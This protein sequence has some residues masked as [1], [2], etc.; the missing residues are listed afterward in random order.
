MPIDALAAG[1]PIAT[2]QDETKSEKSGSLD[3]LLH[4]AT[5]FRF[6]HTP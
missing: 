3:K 2:E 6:L 4:Q 5:S 1:S